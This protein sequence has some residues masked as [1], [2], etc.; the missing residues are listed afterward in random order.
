MIKLEEILKINLSKHTNE[1]LVMWFAEKSKPILSC[2]CGQGITGSLHDLKTFRCYKCNSSIN[3]YKGTAFFHQR[4]PLI[5]W[6]WLLQNLM[7]K[8]NQELQSKLNQSNYSFK[9]IRE[10]AVKILK[11]NTIYTA[12]F[13]NELQNESN[14]SGEPQINSY[15]TK[16]DL[17]PMVNPKVRFIDNKVLEFKR[18]KERSNFKPVY[19]SQSEQDSYNNEE[20]IYVKLMAK[21]AYKYRS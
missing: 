8:T 5:N 13:V 2:V 14:E 12:E 21:L 16:A 4:I 18:N 7:Y 10:I 19:S 11:H 6:V 15:F 20:F 17:E 9:N 1:S 3:L